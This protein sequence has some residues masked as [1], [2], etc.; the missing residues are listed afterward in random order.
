MKFG[1]LN[2]PGGDTV[3]VM[4]VG[5]KNAHAQ[6]GKQQRLQASLWNSRKQNVVSGK[7]TWETDL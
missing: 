4:T 3:W 5:A 6:T 7:M 2:M 1:D